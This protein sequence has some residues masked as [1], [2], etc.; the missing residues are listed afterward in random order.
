VRSAGGRGTKRL[1]SFADLVRLKVVKNLSDHGL[2]LRRIR[3]CLQHLKGYSPVRVSPVTSLKYL[4]D[5]RKLLVL[6]DDRSKILDALD[7]QFVFSLAI[8]N[9]I[10][11]L[12]GE[13]QR[14]EA[15]ALSSRRVPFMARERAL[16]LRHKS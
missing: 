13:V 6:T 8:G 5:G 2:S 10:R 14:F 11:E 16:A 12:N 3:M 4:T 9:L 1:Y 15:R 7:R